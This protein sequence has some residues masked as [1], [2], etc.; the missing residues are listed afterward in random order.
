MEDLK[1]KGLKIYNAIFQGEKTLKLTRSNT[2]LKNFQA[3]LNMLIY[4]GTAL[5][6]KIATKSQNGGKKLERAI[7]LCG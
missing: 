5:S 2:P 6:N 1:E 3:E 4:L 7:K